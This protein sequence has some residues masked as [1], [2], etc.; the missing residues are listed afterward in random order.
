MKNVVLA[1]ATNR[2][3]HSATREALMRLQIAG[4]TLN[5]VEGSSDVALARNITLSSVLEVFRADES[6]DVALLVDDDMVFSLKQ[7]RTVCRYASANQVATSAVYPTAIGGMAASTQFSPIPG[8]WVAGL[9]FFAIPRALLFKLAEDSTRFLWR[10]KELYEFT[11][12]AVHDGLWIGED[13]WLSIRLGG[14][15]LLPIAVGHLKMI[16]LFADRTTLEKIAAKWV[17]G[18]AIDDGLEIAGPFQATTS[19]GGGVVVVPRT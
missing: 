6:R 16:P 8:R 5:T 4:A 7:A 11:N 1:V 18:H 9:G 19:E 12:S 10:G 14:V 17:G 13:Y 3:I 2:P 15:E